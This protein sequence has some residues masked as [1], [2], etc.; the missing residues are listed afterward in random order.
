MGWPERET[1]SWSLCGLCRGD[2][3]ELRPGRGTGN[4]EGAGL[5]DTVVW[6]PG[7]LQWVQ[8]A[9]KTR[10][11]GSVGQGTLGLGLRDRDVGEGAAKTEAGTQLGRRR[12]PGEGEE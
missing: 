8:R 10:G 7:G 5:E 9:W 4:P 6:S 11:E 1:S 2:A 3:Q 12:W